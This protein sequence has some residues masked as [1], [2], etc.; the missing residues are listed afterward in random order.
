MFH[1]S[2]YWLRRLRESCI[3]RCLAIPIWSIVTVGSKRKHDKWV[4]RATSRNVG[5]RKSDG[6]HLAV[7]L[8]LCLLFVFATLYGIALASSVDHKC[9]HR[10]KNIGNCQL[11]SLQII[12]IMFAPSHRL[13]G[14]ECAARKA[15]GSPD[16]RPICGRDCWIL[17][18][19]TVTHTPIWRSY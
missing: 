4:T 9:R 2:G 14:R 13:V 7:S 15:D 17:D 8:Q 11:A 6:S 12:I 1:G 5:N 3:C 10:W 19:W 16:P 18:C